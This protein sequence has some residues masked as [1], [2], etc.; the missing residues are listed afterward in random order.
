VSLKDEGLEAAMSG[1]ENAV[2][3]LAESINGLHAGF[4]SIQS[5][6]LQMLVR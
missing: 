6:N 5:T 4:T 2:K 1:L 3:D